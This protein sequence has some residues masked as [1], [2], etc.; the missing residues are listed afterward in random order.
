MIGGLRG[1]MTIALDRLVAL[2]PPDW[3]LDLHLLSSTQRKRLTHAIQTSI[4]VAR[5]REKA[6]QADVQGR[7]LKPIDGLTHIQMRDRERK[8]KWYHDHK[9]KVLAKLKAKRAARAPAVP[10]LMKREERKMDRDWDRDNL[11]SG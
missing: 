5:R 11:V 7:P 6:M 4:W 3:R 2:C 1:T 10:S 8:R 9:L